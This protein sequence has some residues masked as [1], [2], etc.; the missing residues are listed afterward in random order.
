MKAEAPSCTACGATTSIRSLGRRPAKLVEGYSADLYRCLDCNTVFTFPMVETETLAKFYHDVFSGRFGKEL[1]QELTSKQGMAE[2]L[3][4]LVE[5]HLEKSKRVLD[6]G[7]GLG[8]WLH[9]LREKGLYQE[10]HGLEYEPALV[11]SIKTRYPWLRIAQGPAEDAEILVGHEKFSMISMIAVIEHLH[12]PQ[13]VI[14]YIADHLEPGGR[15]IIVYPRVDSFWGKV[16]GQSWHLFSPVAHLT[17]YSKQGL[18][19][20]LEGRGLRVISNLKF[21]QRFNLH[22]VLTFA[23]H[24]LPFKRVSQ[25]AKR[26][27]LVKSIEFSVY[28]GVDII[29][30][31]K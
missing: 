26:L 16:M 20:S 9:L 12:D 15:T 19:Q 3:Y 22:Y 6:I 29:I 28:T 21:T 7:P 30:A 18:I 8:E 11:A 31:T 17:L 23:A 1:D 25:L 4:S 2:G 10:Y 27:P 5:G 14:Q 24:L 13:K